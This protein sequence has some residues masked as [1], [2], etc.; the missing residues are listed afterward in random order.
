MKAKARA[1][2][3]IVAVVVAIWAST[4]AS[5]AGFSLGDAANYAV[6]YEG[7]G[8]HNLQINSSPLNGS[9]IKGDIGL[10]VENGGNPQAQLNNPA[11]INGNVNFAAGMNAG[12]QNIGNAVV[13]GTVSY[14]VGAVETDLN[15]L[16]ALSLALGVES[17]SALTIN[18][19]GTGGS[20]TINAAAGVLDAGG[21]R[22]FNLTSMTFNNG[23]TLTINGDGAGDS[24][25]INVNKSSVNGPHF[26]GTIL[27]AGGLTPNQV[28]INLTG[29][30]SVTLS[31]G[32]TLQTS[33]NN[34]Y[35]YC[36][37]LDPDGTITLNSVNIVG[38]VYGGDS[39]DMQIVSGATIYAAVPEPTTWLAGV[40]LLLPFGANTLRVVRR[41]LPLQ[42]RYQ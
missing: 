15:N 18:L 16:N 17:G 42:R 31:G 28:L 8:S 25:V 5:H 13:N 3:P 37:Y 7:S 23:N 39:S 6:L 32:D 4:C 22:V 9:T 2:S 30:N 12:N 41:N 19:S 10:G 26:A 29:G 1:S 38:H 14:G 33:A 21:N 24:V 20:Q 36:T 34:A 11:V 40:L 35:Q 27:L